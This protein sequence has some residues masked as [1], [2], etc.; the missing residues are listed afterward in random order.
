MSD[1]S[2]YFTYTD[3][4]NNG[5]PDSYCPLDIMVNEMFE[6]WVG[7]YFRRK[8]YDAR[9]VGGP[10]DKGCDVKAWKIDDIGRKRFYIIQCKRYEPRYKIASPTIRDLAG[11]IHAEQA[12]GGFLVTTSYF[13]DDAITEAKHQGNIRLI[14]RDELLSQTVLVLAKFSQIA[15]DEYQQ[16]ETVAPN[17]FRIGTRLDGKEYSLD[18]DVFK[19]HA[20]VFGAT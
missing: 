2:K 7:E 18:L 15:S 17:T 12:D 9:V 20:I 14:N 13:T 5:L 6:S 8:G 3:K 10:K 16:R 19:K 1:H 11:T 4:N